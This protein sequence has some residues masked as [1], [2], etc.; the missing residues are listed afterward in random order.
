M[1]AQVTRLPWP[2]SL[3]MHLAALVRARGEASCR[4][5][6]Q[7]RAAVIRHAL[8]AYTLCIRGHQPVY[9]FY[10]L[11]YNLH[12]VITLYVLCRDILAAAAALPLAVLAGTVRA[13]VR[14]RGGEAGPGGRLVE[15]TGLERGAAH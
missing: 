2:D 1:R 7:L 6:E 13:G 12:I 8:L 3:A 11:I 15:A 4:E 9:F 14:V 5:A 10:T